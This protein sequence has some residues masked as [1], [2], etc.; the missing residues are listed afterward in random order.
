MK[1]I[2]VL[3]GNGFIG[4]NLCT[5]MAEAGEEVYSFDMS[6]PEKKDS[7]VKYLAGDFFDDYTLS[8][9]LKGMDV[10]YHAICTLN[11]G[12]SNEKCLMGYERDFVQT[13]KLCHMIK[14]TD[15]RLIFLSSGGTVY[16]NQKIQ[17]ISEEAV[18][19]P[20]NHYGNLKLC[21]ENTIR[22][23]NFQSK[24]NMLVARI[25]NPYGPGQDYH[26]GVGFIDA[27]LKRAIHQETIEVWGDGNIVRDYIY[28]DDVC[29]MLYR[30]ASYDGPIEVFNLSSNVGTSQNDV[31]D[32]IKDLIPDVDIKY[33][34]GRSV[35]AGKIIL[36]NERIMKL[37][38]FNLVE[39]STGIRN[40]Y[41]YI[42]QKQI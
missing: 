14:D 4:K 34:A 21:V 40:Y 41:S 10:V 17:P 6:L 8:S 16:G 7:R 1:K 11:P 19:I 37:I 15:C 25:S 12:N 33:S 42:L 30:L 31:L 27:A 9:I 39:I 35:D 26:K 28:I 23:F 18:P 2:L 3:G 29:R 5:L 24:T 32:I 13:A 38:D 36:S 20:I 22:T